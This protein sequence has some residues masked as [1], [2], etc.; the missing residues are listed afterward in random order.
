M[1]KRFAHEVQASDS[2]RYSCILGADLAE[3]DIAKTGH[4]IDMGPSAFWPE[5]FPSSILKGL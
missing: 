3:K 2:L 1:D 4:A 5:S